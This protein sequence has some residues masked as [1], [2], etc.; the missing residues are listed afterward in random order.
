VI[1]SATLP[2]AQVLDGVE[3]HLDAPQPRGEGVQT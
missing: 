2:A 1:V 3:L